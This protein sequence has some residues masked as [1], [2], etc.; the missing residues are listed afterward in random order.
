MS[1]VNPDKMGAVRFVCPDCISNEFIIYLHAEVEKGAS[2]A[3]A[4][5]VKISQ[6]V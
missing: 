2:G 3:S 6:L 5:R 4:A 1:G